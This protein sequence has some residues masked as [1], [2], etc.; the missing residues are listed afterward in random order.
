MKDRTNNDIRDEFFG[1]IEV[2]KQV[3]NLSERYKDIL[4]NNNL[5][6][7]SFLAYYSEIFKDLKK[8]IK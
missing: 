3:L 5:L 2:T 7:L 8:V 6:F 1:Y 4:S